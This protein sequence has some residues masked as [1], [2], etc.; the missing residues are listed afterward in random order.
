MR[1]TLSQHIIRVDDTA[2]FDNLPDAGEFDL[3]A[4][5]SGW[6]GSAKSQRGDGTGMDDREA[7]VLYVGGVPI[8]MYDLLPKPVRSRHG[9]QGCLASVDLDGD[10]DGLVQSAEIP[11][12]HR[13]SIGD[14][15]QGKHIN[16]S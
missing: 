3:T 11:A 14:T 13:L 6:V 7:T 2:R 8:E 4:V 1:P 5:G 10:P 9:F 15:C 12:E 16:N